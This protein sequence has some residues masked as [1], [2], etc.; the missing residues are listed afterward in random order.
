[1][2]IDDKV[3]PV[4]PVTVTMIGTGDGSIQKDTIA[5]TPG[6][7][8]NLII[9]VVGP[10]RAILIRFLNAYFTM[11]VGLVGA[12]LTTNVIP[13]S[14]FWHLVLSCAQLSIAGAGLGALKDVVTVFGKLETKYPLSTGSV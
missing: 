8:P 9:T 6:A 14:D 10:F 3:A 5:T 2:P 12:G 11:L 4:A 13:A 7:Q 1:M